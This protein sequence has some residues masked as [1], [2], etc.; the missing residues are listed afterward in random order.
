[1][2][3]DKE[4]Y[5]NSQQ[6]ITIEGALKENSQFFNKGAIGLFYSPQSC[7]FGR[8]FGSNVTDEKNNSLVFGAIFEARI[9][10][11]DGELRWLK[12]PD[13]LGQAVLLTRDELPSGSKKVEGIIEVIK[14][15]YLLWG[16]GIKRKTE[17]WSFLS[18]ARIGTLAVPI[19][20]IKPNKRVSLNYIEYLK[21]ADDHGNVV[22]AEERL[23][24]LSEYNIVT[25]NG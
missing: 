4:L 3:E 24:G 17:N 8:V 12:Q 14:S 15:Q 7:Q 20:N 22:V 9:F 19:A 2:T 16:E 11:A 10:N 21:I 25:E 18:S 1:M 5:G 23:I 13:G 6:K